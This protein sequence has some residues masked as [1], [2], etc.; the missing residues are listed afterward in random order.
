MT[1]REILKSKGHYIYNYNIGLLNTLAV[2]GRPVGIIGNLIS[3]DLTVLARHIWGIGR[4][5]NS[6]YNAHGSPVFQSKNLLLNKARA[7]FLTKKYR[8][9]KKHN[10]EINTIN[11][12]I[13][14]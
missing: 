5:S 6:I 14:K 3:V 13:K 7:K 10:I 11:F 8:F 1:K 4:A 12:P 9:Y 2:E